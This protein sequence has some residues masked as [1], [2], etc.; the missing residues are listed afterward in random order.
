[1]PLTTGAVFVYGRA[2]GARGNR[3]GV[4]NR[5]AEDSISSIPRASDRPGPELGVLR[6]SLP[7][8]AASF[9]ICLGVGMRQLAGRS[10]IS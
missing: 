9:S 10:V 8:A 7:T 6:G 1:M 4:G 2:G 3:A 5:V